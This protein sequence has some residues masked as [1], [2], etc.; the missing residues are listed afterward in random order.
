MP[1]ALTRLLPAARRD[2]LPSDLQFPP[3]SVYMQS[4]TECVRP[5]KSVTAEVKVISHDR[6][7]M[8]CFRLIEACMSK[9][10]MCTLG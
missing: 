3:V 5:T 10:H 8:L 1:S 2:C 9:S 6:D 4:E 7:V